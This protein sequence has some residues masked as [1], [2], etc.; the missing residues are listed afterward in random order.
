ML[1]TI[2]MFRF[3]LNHINPFL[4]PVTTDGTVQ[5]IQHS[6]ASLTTNPSIT[7]TQAK[8]IPTRTNIKPREH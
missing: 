4:D 1:Y 3:C 8:G 5:K 2:V 6:R 7:R